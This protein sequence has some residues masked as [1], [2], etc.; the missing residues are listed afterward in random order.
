MDPTIYQTSLRFNIIA[1]FVVVEIT[2][3]NYSVA[4]TKV[5]KLKGKLI[6]QLKQMRRIGR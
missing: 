6:I 3:Q 5:K 2:S 4:K 1:T